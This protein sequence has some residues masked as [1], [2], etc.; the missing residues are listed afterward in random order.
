MR[1]FS[2]KYLRAVD[3]LIIVFIF[4][5]TFFLMAVE[6]TGGGSLNLLG[7]N[8]AITAAILSLGRAAASTRNRALGIVRDFYP[9]PMIFVA[10]KEVHVVIQSMARTDYDAAFIAVDR[11]MFGV[12]PTV[13]ISRFAHPA[14]TEL[15]QLSY[16][17]YYFIM[18]ALGVEL[19]RRDPRG[20]FSF[21]IF[22]VV[23]GFFLSYAGYIAFPGVGPRFTLHDFGSLNT[24]LPGLFLTNFLRDAINAG[25]SIPRGAPNPMELAQRDVF[26]SGHTQMTLITM[27]FS[28]KYAIRS[29]HVITV[30]GTLLIISTVYLRYHYVIDL[31][32]GAVFMAL[33][34]TT[35]PLLTGR[36]ARFS[37][38]VDP[39][40]PTP[41]SRE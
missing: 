7:V 29:R 4:A 21:V 11:W 26:P 5:L 39:L 17:S 2:L 27:Y 28:W 38:A 40:G 19:Y 18:I 16:T 30:L 13:W 9:V 20:V 33:T 3:A 12:D 15:L 41:G 22:T 8:L 23:Y 32:G 35:A 37:G 24:E 1:I 25:E 36:W 34:V 6:G 31:V 14:L 10:F